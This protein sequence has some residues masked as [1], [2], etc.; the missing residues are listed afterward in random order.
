MLKNVVKLKKEFQACLAQGPPR[1]V[2]GDK[3]DSAVM[4]TKSVEWEEFRKA[5]ETSG[6]PPGSDSP[7]DAEG[8]K[9]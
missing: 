7:G 1:Q 2:S 5:T 6:W 4:E 3:R 8:S 9:Y